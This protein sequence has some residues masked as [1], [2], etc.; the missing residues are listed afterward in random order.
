M[1]RSSNRGRKQTVQQASQPGST[2]GYVRGSVSYTSTPTISKVWTMFASVNARH[3]RQQ[4]VLIH[5]AK[6]PETLESELGMMDRLQQE[7]LH[8]LT[9]DR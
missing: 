4:I 2:P 7:L 1:S 8:P 3:R 6:I 9:L 5:L